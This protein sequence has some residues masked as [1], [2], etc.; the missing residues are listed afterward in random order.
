[1]DVASLMV[2]NRPPATPA[3][4]AIPISRLLFTQA[5]PND[6]ARRTGR[7]PQMAHPWGCV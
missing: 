4:R 1:M 2:T 3:V 5:K 6:V 7:F